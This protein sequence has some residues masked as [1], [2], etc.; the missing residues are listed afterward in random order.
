MR[1][2]VRKHG[3]S[4]TSPVS[5]DHRRPVLSAAY[6]TVLCT[7]PAAD[8]RKPPSTWGNT[9]GVALHNV[10]YR[11]WRSSDFRALWVPG[12]EPG[13]RRSSKVPPAGVGL[14]NV[15]NASVWS[16]NPST[17]STASCSSPTT[18]D[19]TDADPTTKTS[20]AQCLTLLTNGTIAWNTTHLGAA[21][22]LP[23]AVYQHINLYSRYD[24]TN[25]T[26]PS[27]GQLRP[28]RHPT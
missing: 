2:L 3:I 19:S 14:A 28:L 20:K 25:P 10:R 26:T 9:T 1:P 18:A 24:F 22:H 11:T 6:S 12:W 15:Q 4:S 17:P 27:P 7:P 13:G 16:A 21:N 5:A 23:P 8:R